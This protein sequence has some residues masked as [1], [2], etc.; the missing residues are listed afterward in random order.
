M[1]WKMWRKTKYR[2]PKNSQAK[3]HNTHR[4]K[5]GFFSASVSIFPRDC[6][7]LECKAESAT[8]RF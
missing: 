1:G 4:E 2:K 6:F 5:A 3:E 7:A 8:F